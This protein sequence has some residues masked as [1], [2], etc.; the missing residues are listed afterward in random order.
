MF[1]KGHV[2]AA[3][4]VPV[5][6]SHSGAKVPGGLS[7]IASAQPALDQ[8]NHPT[9]VTRSPGWRWEV[10]VFRVDDLCPRHDPT[11]LAQGRTPRGAVLTEGRGHSKDYGSSRWEGPGGRGEASPHQSIG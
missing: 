6:A 10:R 9:G 11:A 3:P 1:V 7:D 8:V 5:V 2:L 4:E